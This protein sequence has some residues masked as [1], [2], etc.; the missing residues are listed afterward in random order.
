MLRRYC[1]LIFLLL[2]TT[3]LLSQ[4]H[5]L[6]T[7]A[8]RLYPGALYAVQRDD[9]Q[10]KAIALTIDDGPSPATANILSILDRYDAKATFFNISDHLSGYESIVQQSVESGHELGNHLTADEPSIRLDIADFETALL[11]SEAALL[12]YLPS[13]SQ[14]KWLRPG[15]GF[16]NTK[17]IEVAQRHGYQVV[18]GSTFP[19]DTHIHSSRFASEFI[20]RTVQSGDIVVLH[21]GE[22]RGIRTAKTLEIILPELQKRGYNVTTLS[23]L[24]TSD[25]TTQKR[26]QQKQAAVD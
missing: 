19:Y 15:M 10:P 17:M 25:L 4:P 8:N 24:A 16:Y 1:L 23:N 7:L 20:L 14:L 18:L 22:D 2:S 12:S 13:D 6:F 9:S 26:Q 3:I 11:T 5:W 21:D